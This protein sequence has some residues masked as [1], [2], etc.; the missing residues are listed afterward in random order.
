[1]AVEPG[2]GDDAAEAAELRRLR[3]RARRGLLENDLLIGRFLD[4]QGGNLDAAQKQALLL[5][6]ELPDAEL[7]DLLLSR[8]EPV[9]ALDSPGLR[10]LLARMRTA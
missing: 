9:A 1:M 10:A 8:T 3:W 7:L 4:R 2:A 6:L 5:L